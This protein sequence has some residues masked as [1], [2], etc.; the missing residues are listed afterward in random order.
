MGEDLGLDA[1]AELV[2]DGQPP[3][4]VQVAGEPEM[5][6]VAGDHRRIG[7]EARAAADRG[8]AVQERLG[9]RSLFIT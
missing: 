5:E 1:A 2:A 3:G 4:Q 8:K 7:I 9:E 6:K